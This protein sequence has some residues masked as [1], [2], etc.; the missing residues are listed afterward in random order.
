M[1]CGT[2]DRQPCEVAVLRAAAEA[3]PLSFDAR[4]YLSPPRRGREDGVKDVG[5]TQRAGRSRP[6]ARAAGTI[7]VA[8]QCI[9]SAMQHAAHSIAP[10]SSP[11]SRSRWRSSSAPSRNR[12][13]FCTM[14]AITDIVNFGDWRRMRM[15]L[16]AI[17]VAIAGTAR[18]AGGRPDRHVEDDLHDRRRCRGCRTSSAASCSAS[19]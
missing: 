5:R 6:G 8:S 10:L 15:W 4:R 14:G 2:K 19:A 18:A 16:L 17:A 13:N 9:I 12:V 7:A 11:G 1:L 3:G